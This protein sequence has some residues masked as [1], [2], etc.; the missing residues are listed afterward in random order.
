M[1]NG[2]CA[3]LDVLLIG[4]RSRLQPRN[5]LWRRDCLGR[6]AELATLD[7][8]L[9]QP[10][11]GRL[12]LARRRRRRHANDISQRTGGALLIQIAFPV[13]TAPFAMMFLARALRADG[14]K[15]GKCLGIVHREWGGI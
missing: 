7:S 5:M 11:G 15:G 6:C 4:P 1:A 8:I 3:I 10:C 14:R 2:I 12:A 9:I 13:M